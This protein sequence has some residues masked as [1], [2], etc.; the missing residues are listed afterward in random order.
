MKIHLC[1]AYLSL[2]LLLHNFAA[3]V[4]QLLSAGVYPATVRLQP[5][6]RALRVE[7]Y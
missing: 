7:R 5:L 4:V 3:K 6:C 2:L 1:I